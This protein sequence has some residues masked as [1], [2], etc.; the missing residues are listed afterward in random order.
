MFKNLAIFLCL[1]SSLHAQSV[2]D[3]ARSGTAEKMEEYLKKFP[4]HVNLISEHGSSPFLLAAY[5]GNNEVA[6]LLI[7]KGADLTYCYGEGSAIYALIYKNNIEMLE[8]ILKKGVNVNDTCQFQQLGYPIHFA[9]TLQRYDAISLLLKYNANLN[10]ID[11]QERTIKQLLILYNDP[12]YDEIF[13]EIE[14]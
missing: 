2:F 12:K 6:N 5:R 10:I 14:R 8:V 7:E 11:Q 4:E 13:H 9:L 3:V 1:S